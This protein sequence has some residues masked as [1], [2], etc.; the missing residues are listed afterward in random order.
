MA[1][2]CLLGVDRGH[3][4][5]KKKRT[6]TAGAGSAAPHTT[7]RHAKGNA[8]AACYSRFS[9]ILKR[10]VH[11]RPT[12]LIWTAGSCALFH[13]GLVLATIEPDLTWP[14]MWRVR[15]P[16]G[17]LTDMV[18]LSRAKDAAASLALGVLNR[19]REA[20]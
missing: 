12:R 2:G 16:E 11:V 13:R 10:I 3:W 1:G 8:S 19:H 9:P 4:W 20:A 14:G 18:N 5:P 6:T 17:Y 15:L 7:A